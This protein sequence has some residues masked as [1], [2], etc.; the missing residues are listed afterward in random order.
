[1]AFYALLSA[2]PLFLV[3]LYTVGGIFGRARTASALFG[4]LEIW[5]APEGVAA[6]RTLTERLEH[7]TSSRILGIILIAYGSTRLFRALRHALNVLWGI[8]IHGIER[9]RPTM[10]RYGIRYGGAL[11]LILLVVLLVAVLVIAKATFAFM[12]TLGA[13]PP[14][15]LLW[16]FDIIASVTTAFVLFTALFRFLPE[17]RVSWREALVSGLVSTVLF[18]LGSTLVTLYLRLREMADLYAGAGALVIAILWAYYSTQVFFFGAS[19][20]VAL[21]QKRVARE[22]ATDAS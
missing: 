4:G 15:G 13:E 20:G 18:A 7:H 11:A 16:A 6:V 17:T 3:V 5:L 1:M 22:Q 8:D 19:V 2:A 21:E 14:P 12:A 9:A 10:L